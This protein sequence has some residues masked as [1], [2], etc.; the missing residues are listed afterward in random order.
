MQHL[1]I[2]LCKLEHGFIFVIFI[3]LLLVILIRKDGDIFIIIPTR[4]YTISTHRYY[5]GLNFF[6]FNYSTA[7]HAPFKSGI[8][9]VQCVG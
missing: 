1:I 3:Y 8:D 2:I 5:R 4:S 9:Y 7:L 6:S